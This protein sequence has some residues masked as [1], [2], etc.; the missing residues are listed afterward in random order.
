MFS[1]FHGGKGPGTGN[2]SSSG[3]QP[4]SDLQ[5]KDRFESVFK[6]L[7]KVLIP[8]HAEAGQPVVLM[9]ALSSAGRGVSAVWICSGFSSE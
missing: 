5:E 8:E 3:I 4:R 9:E 7:Q 2:F 6:M 1:Q